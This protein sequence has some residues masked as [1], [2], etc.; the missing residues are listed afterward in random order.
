[1]SDFVNINTVVVSYLFVVTITTLK[2][3]Q[4]IIL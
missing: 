2:R 4:L 3:K 1:M